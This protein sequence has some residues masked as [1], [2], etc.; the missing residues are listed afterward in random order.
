LIGVFAQQPIAD[1]ELAT[2]NRACSIFAQVLRFIP[3]LEFEAAVREHG[4]E[5][6]TLAYANEHR[7]WELFATVFRSLYQ[8]CQADAWER[9]RRKFRF[10]H[11]L[12]SLDATLIPAGQ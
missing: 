6:S 10:K 7:R 8:R 12:L 1:Q 5:R 9:G 3:R 2:M 11:T 4:A